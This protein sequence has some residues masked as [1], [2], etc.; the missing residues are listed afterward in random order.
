MLTDPHPA[1][2]HTEQPK[3]S[4]AARLGSA[5]R[6]VNRRTELFGGKRLDQAD[7]ELDTK[8]CELR[9]W[10][11]DACANQRQRGIDD[12]SSLRQHDAC[13]RRGLDHKYIGALQ[14]CGRRDFHQHRLVAQA[15]NHPLKQSPDIIVGLANQYLCHVSMID[16]PREIQ[17]GQAV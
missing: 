9:W 6:L 17:G 8:L 10:A 3:R 1:R 5:Q 2:S 7:G 12:A 13:G 14:L 16:R 4:V 11:A 15:G